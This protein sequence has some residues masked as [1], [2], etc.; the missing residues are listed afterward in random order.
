MLLA[1]VAALCMGAMLVGLDRA[2]EYDAYWAVLLA[3]MST[4]TFLLLVWSMRRPSTGKG[5]LRPVPLVTVGLLDVSANVLWTVATTL[6]LLS[7]VAVLGGLFP[8]VT[9]LLSVVVLRE[10]LRRSQ[11]TGAVM[12]LAGAG[13]LS[14]A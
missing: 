5:S 9:V 4:V 8:A 2:A 6:G 14:T 11:T 3:R 13:L 7:I 12:A 1:L 10:R